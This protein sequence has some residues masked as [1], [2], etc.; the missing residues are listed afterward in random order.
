MA[1]YYGLILRWARLE[2]REHGLLGVTGFS[3]WESI[4]GWWWGRDHTT[5]HIKMPLALC[6]LRVMAND[7][8]QIQAIL[9]DRLGA[10]KQFR[11][12]FEAG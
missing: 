7:T 11:P 4:L 2:L 3:T 1:V 8:D 10:S 12:E 6:S 5:L 9:E